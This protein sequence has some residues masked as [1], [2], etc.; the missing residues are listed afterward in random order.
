MVNRGPHFIWDELGR[1]LEAHM[2]L[3]ETTLL[4]VSEAEG[5]EQVRLAERIR[6]EQQGVRRIIERLGVTAQLPTLRAE[7]VRE[8]VE[9]LRRHAALEDESLYPRADRFSPTARRQHGFVSEAPL[10]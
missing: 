5:L 3:E 4:P 2:T 8:L 6:C 1:R 10:G 9:L 7:D